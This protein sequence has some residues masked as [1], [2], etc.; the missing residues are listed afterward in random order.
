MNDQY[1]RD[2]LRKAEC[3]GEYDEN[4]LK[5]RVKRIDVYEKRLIICYTEIGSFQMA[6]AGGIC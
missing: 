2:M 1:V 4:V 6:M 5:D 3:N